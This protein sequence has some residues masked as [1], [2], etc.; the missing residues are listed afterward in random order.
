[1]SFVILLED[2]ELGRLKLS[3]FDHLF[4][5]SLTAAVS[6]YLVKKSE[7]FGKTRS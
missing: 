7:K 4:I 3:D 6:M 2:S 1:M 5:S